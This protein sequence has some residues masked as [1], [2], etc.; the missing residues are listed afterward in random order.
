MESSQRSTLNE[1]RGL[2]QQLMQQ[3]VQRLGQMQQSLNAR[4]P[5]PSLQRRNSE[6]DLATV[7]N[8]LPVATGKGNLR[9]QVNHIQGH[10]L[11]YAK[12]NQEFSE[13]VGGAKM[14][15]V[16]EAQFEESEDGF[17]L[18]AHFDKP[19]K[20]K[21][22]NQVAA[23]RRPV[24]ASPSKAEAKPKPAPTGT[25]KTK[26]KPSEKD[27]NLEVETEVRRAR[28]QNAPAMELKKEDD[29][30]K[31]PEQHEGT[32]KAWSDFDVKADC[33]SLRKA[34]KGLGTDEKAIIEVMGKRSSTQRLQLV[35]QY[36]TTYGK[37]LIKEFKSELSG[38]FFKVIE[39]LCWAP[40]EYDAHEL[41]RAMK[42]LGTDDNCLIEVLCTRTNAQI[43]TL[44]N[45]YKEC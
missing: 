32:L 39:A 35:Q 4:P 20:S 34:M 44:K 9:S 40:D 14:G 13:Q 26:T 30:P 42:G 3:T 27:K 2:L 17:L 18:T 29:P 11:Q 1:V 38:N 21:I 5:T 15:K 7:N 41:H 31:P 8:A 28:N 45:R 19:V 16:L 24:S 22:A 33:E 23:P 25:S 43:D 6:S 37:D 12:S 10:L 36:K